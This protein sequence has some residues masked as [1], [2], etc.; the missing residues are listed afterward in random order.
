MRY[1]AF[2]L[3]ALVLIF[4]TGYGIPATK[5]WNLTAIQVPSTVN[6]PHHSPG[7]ND[8]VAS[9]DEFRPFLSSPDSTISR[10]SYDTAMLKTNQTR[11][12]RIYNNLRSRMLGLDYADIPW[13]AC[14]LVPVRVGDGDP[15]VLYNHK[16]VSD[17]ANCDPG[18]Q[19]SASVMKSFTFTTMLQ[20]TFGQYITGELMTGS[21]FYLPDVK[22]LLTSL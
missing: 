5:T 11:L 1:T 19:C 3:F 7:P 18:T 2:V 22:F 13:T 4:R 6:I 9:A 15:H 21:V 14:P 16:Q 20:A 8:V 10:K 12:K 17:T